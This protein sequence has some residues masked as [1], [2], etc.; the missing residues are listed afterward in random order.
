MASIRWVCI[1]DLHL[2]AL[3][4]LL[5]NVT[6][7]GQHV[8]R[9]SPSPVLSSLCQCLESL[10]DGSERPPQLVL[11]GDL[12]ELAL[13]APEDAAATFSQFI[14]TLSPG[15]TG[16]AVDPSLR[17]IPGNHDHHLWSRASD[18]RYVQLLAED[19]TAMP[20][21]RDRH[22]TSLV[23][24]N[25]RVPAR[26][27]FVETLANRG[28]RTGKISVEQSYPNLGLVDATGGRAVVLSHGH[29]IEPLYRMMSLLAKAF[30]TPRSGPTEAWQIEADNGGWIDF[31][32]SSMGN[33]GDIMGIT[34]S[35]YESLQSHEA[36][37][38]EI[39]AIE[40]AIKVA[41]R[42]RARADVEAHAAAALLE[43]GVGTLLRERHHSGSVLSVE[44]EKGLLTYLAGPVAG[45]VRKE[46]GRPGE[47]TF[48][49][50]HTHKPFVAERTVDSF[51]A[52][53]RVANT[54]G[55]VVDTPH[56]DP[57]KGAAI[58]LVD[59]DL[60]VVSLRCYREGATDSTYRV[61]IEPVG[62]G[63]TNRLA[64]ELTGTIDPDRE[65][66]STL[67][68]AISGAV[69]DRGRQLDERLRADTSSLDRLNRPPGSDS[70]H[71]NGPEG[72]RRV[73][74]AKRSHRKPL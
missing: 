34:R 53:V 23:P 30:G 47:M 32:W 15:G 62:G 18:D 58:I 20:T 38:A 71:E 51:D 8:D 28:L 12:F 2:G 7:D 39:Q 59:D 54:G 60:D 50:G 3:N 6:S 44:A 61:L 43:A 46:V 72:D 19:P 55:W 21:A 11:L 13:T 63:G 26:D 48:V 56:L 1:S 31:F 74:F 5:T 68:G 66:W 49:F 27:R 67:A 52:P 45:Q 64:D 22:A 4:S 40:R 29:Y 36:V 33:S 37:H 73:R 65:P 42:S 24:S 10:R 16:S 41:G 9:S 17:F 14:G 70:G 25:V 69:T 35:L 57:V